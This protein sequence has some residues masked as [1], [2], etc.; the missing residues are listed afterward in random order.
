PPPGE[1]S[2]LRKPFQAHGLADSYFPAIQKWLQVNGLQ[3]Q[4]VRNL[5]PQANAPSASASP[6]LIPSAMSPQTRA[7]F[8]RNQAIVGRETWDRA[9]QGTTPVLGTPL[10]QGPD[11]GPNAGASP[12]FNPAT[13]SPQERAGWERNQALV[14]RETLGKSGQGATPALG[15]LPQQD[16]RGGVA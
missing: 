10:Q 2:T 13:L 6:V 12:A 14:G 1:Q 5:L 4:R 16:P 15:N 11:N 7:A 3:Q 9:G 8:E